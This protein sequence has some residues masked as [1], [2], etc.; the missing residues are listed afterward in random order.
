[1]KVVI[2]GGS[3]Q[4]GAL[5]ARHYHSRGDQVVVLSRFPKKSSWCTVIWDPASDGPWREEFDGADVVINLAGRSVNCR[6]HA[7]NRLEILHSRVATTE[8][9]GRAIA[10][11]ARP[12]RVWLQASTAT[13]YPHTLGAANNES[14]DLARRSSQAGPAAWTFSQRVA[15]D[16]ENAALQAETP[17]TRIV[18]MRSAMTMSPDPGG[19]FD[20]LLRLVRWRLGGWQGGGRQFVSWIH[21]VDFVR[22][23]DWLVEND[24]LA[25]PVNLTSPTP[26]PNREFM[27]ALRQAWGARIGMPA[28]R[29][30]VELGALLLRTESELILKSRRVVPTRLIQSGFTFQFPQWAAAAQDLCRRFRERAGQLVSSSAFAI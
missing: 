9:V 10:T 5:L 27:R 25:G 20:V 15:R 2:P 4:I 26:L 28:S 18:L 17:R 24:A 19:V 13:I 30:M 23:V 7:Q 29:P 6:Y 11:S 16:W 3:G 21:D 8:A 22:A 12:P 1:M 14:T